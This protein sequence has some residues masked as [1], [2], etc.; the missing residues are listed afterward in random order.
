MK[1][2]LFTLA[3]LC[4]TLLYDLQL[5]AQN[6]P[7]SDCGNVVISSI[8]NGRTSGRRG[9][10][11]CAIN[12]VPDLSIYHL[13]TEDSNLSDSEFVG[14]NSDGS[15]HGSVTGFSGP[16]LAG[17][18]IWLVDNFFNITDDNNFLDFMEGTVDISEVV[19]GTFNVDDDKNVLLLC[20][21]N[22]DDIYGSYVA[23]LD[24]DEDFMTNATDEIAEDDPAFYGDTWVLS[25]ND[26]CPN[27]GTMDIA[28]WVVGPIDDL[29]EFPDPEGGPF[30]EDVDFISQSS[31]P[32]ANYTNSNSGSCSNVRT[33]GGLEL[34]AEVRYECV[35][36]PNGL[37]DFL[38][39]ID[40]IGME[41]GITLGLLEL[42]GCNITYDASSDDPAT[43]PNG[44]IVLLNVGN[45]SGCGTS[46]NLWGIEFISPG[47]DGVQMWNRL[48]DVCILECSN[49]VQDGDETGIDCGGSCPNVCQV[50]VDPTCDDGIMN[51]DETGVDCGGAT[52]P[53]CAMATC[54]D[55]VMNGDETGVD[56]GGATCPEC[57][58][59]GTCEDGIMNG[60]E[61]GVDCGGATCPDCMAMAT[62]DDGIM[63]GDET[64]VDCGGATCPECMAMATCDDGVMN[65]DETGVDCGGANCPE[66]GEIAAVPTMSQWGLIILMLLTLTFVSITVITRQGSL[67]GSNRSFTMS[68]SMNLSNYPFNKSLFMK[69][70]AFVGA[71]ALIAA[72]GTFAIYGFLTMTDIIGTMIAGPIFAYLI[73]L[74]VMVNDT[75]K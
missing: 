46:S 74:L 48:P 20:R 66:C 51:G 7:C 58:A 31:Y 1:K 71:A 36:D 29:D 19:D 21:G 30:G 42:Y 9:I 62:C 11:I 52:C 25:N 6:A 49:G 2:M 53:A 17:E 32:G 14:Y 28:N 41:P 44:T 18:C 63:N 12:D 68:D 72:T 33:C 16:L 60:D 4:V 57:M 67:A 38:M 64:G 65:G 75:E 23:A 22:I 15:P 43:T 40:Y 45:Q 3:L 39:K 10:Q 37:D 27:G 55:G 61:T 70:F 54:D 59:M 47:C 5:Q 8:V 56:C 50:T 35:E 24:E 69:A 13:V 34:C 26:R 73:H